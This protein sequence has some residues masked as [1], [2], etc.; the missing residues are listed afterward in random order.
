MN[1]ERYIIVSGQLAKSL[2]MEFKHKLTLVEGEG[3]TWREFKSPFG[4]KVESITRLSTVRTSP[5]TMLELSCST[6]F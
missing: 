1:Q 3:F 6:L 4:V 5:L 2:S